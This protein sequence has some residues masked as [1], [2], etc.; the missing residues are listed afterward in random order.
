MTMNLEPALASEKSNVSTAGSSM[1]YPKR[2][3]NIALLLAA[4]TA[5]LH[6]YIGILV[7]GIPLGV[8]LILIALVYIGGIVL[9]AANNRRDR[10]LKIGIYW[11]I[12]I[13]ALWAA[14]AAVNAPNTNIVLAYVDKAVE[15]ILL[16]ILL[17]IRTK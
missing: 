2:L 14:S 11:V 16:G 10:W 4:V 1:H 13:I 17:R 9:I 15:F 12:I 5:I 7:Y 8:P 3:L 6:L